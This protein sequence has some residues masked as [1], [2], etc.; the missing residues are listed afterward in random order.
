MQKLIAIAL[1]ALLCASPRFVAAG[2]ILNVAVPDRGAW[3]SSYTEFGL[4]LSGL[5]HR[6]GRGG[7]SKTR[8][9]CGMR[10]TASGVRILPLSAINFLITESARTPVRLRGLSPLAPRPDSWSPDLAR[11]GA[12][13]LVSARDVVWSA[14]SSPGPA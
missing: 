14:C 3:D 10:A 6:T 9:R 13:L 11:V 5:R 8:C 7:A 12:L 1:T 4:Q 2:E